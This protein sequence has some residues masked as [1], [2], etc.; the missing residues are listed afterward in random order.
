[1]RRRI[2]A[3]MTLTLLLSNVLMA[4]GADAPAP[5]GGAP[6]RA[7]EPLRVMLLDG[8]SGGSYHAWQQTTPVLRR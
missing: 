8:E 6:G 3:G 7:R 1:M 2:T 4:W 5:Q